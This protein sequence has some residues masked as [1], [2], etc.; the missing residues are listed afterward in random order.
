MPG[1]CE[2]CGQ[3][4]AA[5]AGSRGAQRAGRLAERTV[6]L[7][8]PMAAIGPPG[9]RQG[10][11]NT[12]GPS[13]VTA[14][15]CSK[16]AERR[17]VGRDHAPAVVEEPGLGPPGVHHGLDGEDH[18]GLEGGPRAARPVVGHLGLLVHG[19][20]DGVADVLAD[21]GVAG[22][23][24]HVLDGPAHLV[25]PVPRRELLDPG[26]QAAL[27]DLHEPL[28]LG[29]DPPHGRRV[30][31]VAVVPLDDGPAVDR[32]DVALLQPVVAGD[33]VDDHL[34]G[35]GA[36]DGREPVVAEEV[37]RG[38]PGLEH[39]SGHGVELFGRHPGPQRRPGGLVHLGHHPPGPAHPGQLVGVAPHQGPPAMPSA[40]PRRRSSTAET[41][42]RVTSSGAPVP[43]TSVSGPGARTTRSA[44][45]SGARRA[46]GGA[47]WPPRC[48][49]RAGPPRPRRRRRSR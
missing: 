13:S 5:G 21:H 4:T 22:R 40:D 27:G 47:R 20:P 37:R 12:S 36:D 31:G 43:S 19:R 16:W 15:V 8:A 45:P 26:P 10:T 44:A 39:L 17:A 46:R 32:E 3:N 49:P 42:W 25:E 38:P 7:V 11:V 30:G 24:G 33:A 34:V 9:G 14:M 48:R 41:Q 35:R 29:R 28:G 23:L 1:R 18:A 2:I 6:Y